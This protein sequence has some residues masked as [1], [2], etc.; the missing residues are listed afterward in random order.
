MKN[1]KSVTSIVEALKRFFNGLILL[2]NNDGV[3]VKPFKI[4]KLNFELAN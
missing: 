1:E 3:N 2:K 4:F